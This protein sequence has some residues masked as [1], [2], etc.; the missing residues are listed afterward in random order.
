M[1]WMISMVV[2]CLLTWGSS[3]LLCPDETNPYLLNRHVSLPRRVRLRTKC[4]ARGLRTTMR[5]SLHTRSRDRITPPV[6]SPQHANP[7]TCLSSR[8]SQS[9]PRSRPDF[10]ADISHVACGLRQTYIKPSMSHY[11]LGAAV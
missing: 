4:R 5:P 1:G 8:S 9:S 2:V 7:L 6:V 10:S 11:G 3:S